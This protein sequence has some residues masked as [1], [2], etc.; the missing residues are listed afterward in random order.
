MKQSFKPEDRTYFVSDER[1]KAFHALTPA[2]RLKW[3]EQLAMFLRLA[4]LK[5]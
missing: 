3:V 1:L 5:K 4:K 2:Q